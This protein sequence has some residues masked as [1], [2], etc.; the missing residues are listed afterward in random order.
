MPTIEEKI[1]E[2]YY[3]NLI[4]DS[5]F[6]DNK[7]FREAVLSLCRDFAMSCKPGEKKGGHDCKEYSCSDMDDEFNSALKEWE[8]NIKSL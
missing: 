7:E 8:E 6:K 5:D 2:F 3:D 1:D 4:C